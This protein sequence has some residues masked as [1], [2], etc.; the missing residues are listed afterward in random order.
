MTR[1]LDLLSSDLIAGAL[2]SLSA[3]EQ[4]ERPPRVESGHEPAP[5][6][7]AGQTVF[8][9]SQRATKIRALLT[10]KPTATMT[11]DFMLAANQRSP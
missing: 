6:R 3:S 2:D 11:I 1:D 8:R 5:W 9:A 10:S 7:D 4:R